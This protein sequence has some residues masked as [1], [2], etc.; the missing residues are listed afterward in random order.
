M[1]KSI[2]ALAIL[3]CA[4]FAL[5][6]T[7]CTKSPEDLIIG[8]WILE[9]TEITSVY[10][11]QTEIEQE[12]PDEGE[13]VVFTFNKDLSMTMEDTEVEN[14]TTHTD[15][16]NGTYLITDNTITMTVVDEDGDVE[17]LNFNIDLLDKKE[18]TLSQTQTDTFLGHTYT[19]TVKVQMKRK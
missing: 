8:S 9:Y 15:I 2:K 16:S 7:Q 13:Q 5:C 14:G 19:I 17:T 1:K 3:I 12:T 11:D 6:F 10:D 18:M 4:A